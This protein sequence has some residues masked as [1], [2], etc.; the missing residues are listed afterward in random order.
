[1]LHILSVIFIAANML[2]PQADSSIFSRHKQFG[3]VL[4]TVRDSVQLK[5][6]SSYQTLQIETIRS[7][8][9]S[10]IKVRFGIYE[11]GKRLFGDEWAAESYFDK[12]DHLSDTI[13][14]R[15]LEYLVKV[16][17]INQNF[18]MSGEDSLAAIFDRARPA[19][20]KA[21]SIEAK[22]FESSPHRIFSVFGGRDH[23]YALTWLASKKKFVKV[24][25]N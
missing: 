11:Q 13:K 17:F 20:I 1:M 18:T 25:K 6:D 15:R 19:E 7:T 14:W 23:L 8:R 10:K 4:R 3:S 24:W 5:D 21:G 9:F 12:K 16:F 22:E 2:S